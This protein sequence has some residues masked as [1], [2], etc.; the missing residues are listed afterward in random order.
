[1]PQYGWIYLNRTWMCLNMS[2]FTITDKVLS[3]SSTI[4]TAKT[5]WKK[6][7]FRALSKIWDRALWKI[8][9]AFNYFRKTLYPKFLRGGSEYV[10]GFKYFRVLNFQG[11]TG[12]TCF[13]KYVRVLIPRFSVCPGFWISRVTQGLPIF[14]NMARFWICVGMQLWK[15]SEYSRIPN[16]LGF[17]ICKRYTRFWICLN[18]TE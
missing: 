3:M 10:S 5:Y 18:M 1:M 8:I 7:V 15:S 11:Y 17:C 6:G 9:I 16:M 14:L 13:C 12:L 4:H 2:E